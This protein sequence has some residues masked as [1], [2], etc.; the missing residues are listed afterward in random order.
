MGYS[1]ETTIE[2]LTKKDW[3][4]G[5]YD[6][7]YDKKNN[8]CLNGLWSSKNDITMN[9]IARKRDG[10][11]DIEGNYK[12]TWIQPNN[13]DND[14]VCIIGELVIIK[15]EHYYSFE[16]KVDGTSTYF[17]IGIKMNNQLIVFYLQQH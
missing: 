17:G 12:V 6:I 5:I 7:I 4:F 1:A 10:L 13:K 11:K 9:E 14:D 3:R 16:W 8:L 2:E 15:Q